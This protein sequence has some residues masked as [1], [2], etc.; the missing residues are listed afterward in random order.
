MLVSSSN[1]KKTA[2][3][4]FID[5]L[6]PFKKIPDRKEEDG[7]GIAPKNKEQNFALELLLDP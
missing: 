3:T 7:W 4:R 6:I 1:E 2:I 5:A